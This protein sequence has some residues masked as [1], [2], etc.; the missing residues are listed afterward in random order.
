MS[1]KTK[2]L[3]YALFIILFLIHPL[4]LVYTLASH[5][6]DYH[7]LKK[8]HVKKEAWGLNI[9]CG[10]TDG[11]GVNADVVERDVPNFVKIK[12]IYDLPFQDEEFE[13]VLC[14]HTMEHVEKPDEFLKELK[15]VGE[16][17]TILVPPV[18]DLLGWLAFQ[19]HKWQ[20]LTTET[21]H[22]NKLPP[23]IKLPYWGLQEKLG[24]EIRC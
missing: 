7:W 15:R 10:D 3:D 19:E 12:N 9:C 16:N 23:K 17:V 8:E 14:S 2:A 4:L 11:G 1:A 24:Q 13:T 5:V 21:R 22:E 20:F 18:W 6:V